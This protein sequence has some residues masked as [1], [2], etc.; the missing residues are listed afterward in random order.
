MSSTLRAV[1]PS[2]CPVS[3]AHPP[4]SHVRNEVAEYRP[5]GSMHL[6]QLKINFIYLKAKQM[7][8][9]ASFDSLRPVC[10]YSVSCI[11][12]FLF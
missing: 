8:A 6:N 4:E 5:L 7:L 11:L 12:L 9:D 1:Y 10:L 2:G 3:V